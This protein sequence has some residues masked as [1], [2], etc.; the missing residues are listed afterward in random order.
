MGL[1][2][3]LIVRLMPTEIP[4][5]LAIPHRDIE[6]YKPLTAKGWLTEKPKV[7]IQCGPAKDPLARMAQVAEHQQ[8][9]TVI[10]ICHDK[11]FLDPEM[12]LEAL[13]V[14]HESG[15]DYLYSSKFVDGTGFEIISAKALKAAASQYKDVEHV[16]YAIKCVTDKVLDLP[17]ERHPNPHRLLIDYSEDVKVIDL[18]L[19]RLGNHCTLKEVL[20]FLDQNPALSSMNQLPLI[21]LYTCAYNAEKWI[22]AAMGSVSKQTLFGRCEYLLI[23]DAST[24]ATAYRMSGFA[25]LYKN[26]TK[27][28]RNCENLGL[29]S[30][31]NLALNQARGRYMLRLDADDYFVR[32]SVIAEMVETIEAQDVDILYPANFHGSFRKI[33]RGHI[34]HHVGGALFRTRAANHVRFTD[35]LRG[36]EGYDFLQR[37]RHQVR[38]GYYG[39][40][41][42]FYRQHP[43]SLSQGDPEQ[44]QKIKD[45]ID[46]Q[47]QCEPQPGPA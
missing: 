40:P 22:N 14:F 46:A 13:Q 44:R 31:S 11:I 39:R 27:W 23:D 32:N 9:D 5:T 10:R 8:L 36:Y 25:Y 3:H 20:E 30:C 24:D 45:E 28:S 34:H 19:N 16:S 29:A 4:I 2:E 43:D 47:A 15:L 17:L 21:T 26:N 1:L 33:Q 12:I 7:A 37:A 41:T 42:F 35:G 6:L 18:I 38:I